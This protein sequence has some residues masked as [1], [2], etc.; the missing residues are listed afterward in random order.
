MPGQRIRIHLN[1]REQKLTL[2]CPSK[3]TFSVPMKSF[4]SNQ[5]NDFTDIVTVPCNSRL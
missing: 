3:D 1:T 2:Y 5:Q 4:V